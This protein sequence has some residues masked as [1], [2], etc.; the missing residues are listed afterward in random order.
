MNS[1]MRHRF[2]RTVGTVDVTGVIRG[3]AFVPT[4]DALND[5]VNSNQLEGVARTAFDFVGSFL[6]SSEEV[7]GTYCSCDRDR[8]NAAHTLHRAAIGLVIASTFLVKAMVTF[9]LY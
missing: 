2:L 9:L 7:Q 8:C 1:S 5:C 3:C 4:S 6:L